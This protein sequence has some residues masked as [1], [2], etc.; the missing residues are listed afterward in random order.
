M[1]SGTKSQSVGA[2]DWPKLQLRLPPEMKQ[3]LEEDAALHVRS[4][5]SH[6]LAVLRE[7]MLSQASANQPAK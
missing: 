7:R 3:W 4:M 1:G 5:N 2:R 6:V